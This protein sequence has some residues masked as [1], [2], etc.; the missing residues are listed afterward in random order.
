[1]KSVF[2]WVWMLGLAGFASGFF[3]PMIF[4]PGANQGPLLGIL[5]SGPGGAL[6]GLALGSLA[7]VL[8]WSTTTERNARLACAAALAL[9]TL[10]YCLPGP[11]TRGVLLE[12]TVESCGQPL[13]FEAGAFE[14]W[15]SRI[16]K[17]S[18]AEPRARWKDEA[19]RLFERPDGVVLDLS[20]TSRKAVREQRKPWNRGDLSFEPAPGVGDIHRVFARFAGASCSAYPAGPT[21]LYYEVTNDPQPGP[22]PPD[23]LPGLLGL[24]VAAPPPAAYLG[25]ASSG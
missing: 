23:D 1:V 10:W 21:T 7:R 24:V 20:V 8:P 19:R 14:D 22:W 25:G 2:R 17:A 12:A 4:D 6:A 5:I 16:A 18:W 15:D 13:E 11:L 9:G 3:G